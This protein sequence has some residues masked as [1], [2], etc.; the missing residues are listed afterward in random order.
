MCELKDRHTMRQA[1]WRENMQAGRQAGRDAWRQKYAKG[2]VTNK[3][4]LAHKPT[5]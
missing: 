1:G 4:G 5:D 2:Q 3:E